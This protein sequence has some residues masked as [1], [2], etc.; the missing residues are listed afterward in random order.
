MPIKILMID[1]DHDDQYLYR[2]LF[3]SLNPDLEFEC[4][5]NAEAFFECYPLDSGC[6][7]ACPDLIILDMNL[8]KYNGLEIFLH[9]RQIE[10]LKQV[11]VIILTTSSSPMDIEDSRKLGLHSYFIKPMDY[12]ESKA[13]VESIYRYWFKFNALMTQ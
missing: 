1:D 13:L 7:K 6:E 5:D 10:K 4:T 12:T 11:P 9:I 2:D 3:L 8:P